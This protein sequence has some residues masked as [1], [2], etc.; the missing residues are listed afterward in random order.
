MSGA[1]RKGSGD[2]GI[3]KKRQAI[4]MQTKADI[5]RVE[6]GEISDVA[7]SYQ[8][9]RSTIGTILK[10]KDRIMEHVRRSVPMHST[11]ISKKRGK[12]IEELEN[13][14]SIWME[15]CHQKRKPLRLMLIQEKALSLFED[16]KTK[17]GEEAADVTF[18]A[19]HGWFNRLKAR[20][21]LHNIKVT[22]EAA[23]A[24]TVVA[25]EFPATLK[26]V[27]PRQNM[28]K[29]GLNK[30]RD[31][32]LMSKFG[33]IDDFINKNPSAELAK[34]STTTLQAAKQVPLLPTHSNQS[35]NGH[36]SVSSCVLCEI[37]A[38]PDGICDDVTNM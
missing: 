19:S 16:V 27:V 37:H 26:G 3:S 25:Q 22:G 8:M 18:T 21:N 24:D 5:K 28:I 30:S 6:R 2:A 10:S 32:T 29:I 4:T 34:T 11:V 36:L 31:S 23:S 33:S 7:R 13:L 15:D 9:N 14:L 20:N 38:E 1:K 12:V 17:Y 35:A